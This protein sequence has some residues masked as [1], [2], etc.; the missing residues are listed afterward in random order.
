MS[1]PAANIRTNP[2]KV[3]VVDVTLPGCARRL[4]PMVP[5][6]VL[7]IGTRGTRGMTVSGTPVFGHRAIED[8]ANT[9]ARSDGKLFTTHD[10]D[11]KKRSIIHGITALFSGGKTFSGIVAEYLVDQEPCRS[12]SLSICT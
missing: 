5:E 7:P 10:H 1:A 8:Q 3:I 11:A 12:T 6:I 4:G 2:D 9:I